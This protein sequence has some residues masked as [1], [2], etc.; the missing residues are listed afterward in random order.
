MTLVDAAGQ[1]W[2]MTYVSTTRDNLHSGRLVEGWET[3]C[4]ANKLRI[5]DEVDF[6]KVEAHEQEGGR[7][8]KEAGA[9]V[10]LQKR[11]CRNK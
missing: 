9:R 10:V 5:G 3:F 8:C 6:I 4:C 1:L 2:S 11:N 7:L